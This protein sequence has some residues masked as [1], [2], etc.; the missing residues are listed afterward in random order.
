MIQPNPKS[1]HCGFLSCLYERSAR[2]SYTYAYFK[3][4]SLSH[5]RIFFA[6]EDKITG[7]WCTKLRITAPF[8]SRDT[9]GASFLLWAQGVGIVSE[10]WIR[11]L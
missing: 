10:L 4:G 6:I 5:G 7:L 8:A 9:G 2:R 11:V 3:F 1:W